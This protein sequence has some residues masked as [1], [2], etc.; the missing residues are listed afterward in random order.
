M[1]TK[2]Y[3]P[4][5]ASRLLRT[6]PERIAG[7]VAKELPVAMIEAEAAL[8]QRVFRDGQTESG[9]NIGRYS[10][11]PMYAST[12][13]SRAP[14]TKLRGKGRG[15]GSN[16]R[17]FK[18]GKVRRSRYFAGGYAE[19]RS[20]LGRQNAKVDLFMTGSLRRSITTGTNKDRATMRFG[21]GESTI[22]GR[23]H[24]ERYGRSIFAVNRRERANVY[25]RL[26]QAAQ[27]EVLK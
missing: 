7:A 11:T 25:T 8:K 6:L 3:T 2:S 5:Q 14:Y 22:I 10:T 27:R 13:Q 20:F 18:N 21:D 26:E 17:T 4:R 16:K 24:E 23:G 9:A 1:A 15:K 12:N 19:L